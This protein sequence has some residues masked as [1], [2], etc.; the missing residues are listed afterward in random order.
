MPKLFEKGSEINF[1]YG[2]GFNDKVQYY[3]SNANVQLTDTQ[4]G[5]DVMITLQLKDD[6]LDEVVSRI[7]GITNGSCKH[8]IIG[9]LYI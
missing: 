9:K 5:Q 8:E 3:I 2:Y 4:Y 7:N 1:T 6:I